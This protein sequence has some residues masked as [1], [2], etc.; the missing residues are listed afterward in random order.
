MYNKLFTKILDSSIW[1]APDPHRL[2][3][4]TLIA[5]MDEDGNAMFACADNL[6]A[7][8]RVSVKQAEAAIKSFQEPDPKSGDPDNEGMRIER[9]PG[10]WHVLNAHKYRS[11]VTKTISREQTRLRTAA[12]RERKRDASVTKCDEKVTPSEAVSVSVS[13]SEAKNKDMSAM[14]TVVDVFEHWKLTHNHPRSVLDVKRKKLIKSALNNYSVA[15]LCQ[16]ITGYLKSPHHMGMNEANTIYDDIELMLRDAKHIDAG[17][18]F[19]SNSPRTDLSSLT[20]K[21]VMATQDWQPPEMRN[22]TK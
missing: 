9:I 2:V 8:A 3:W 14:P 12:W 4:I 22:E 20:R 18:R 15:D 13:V 11:I 7:R 17:I 10:G 16:S 19:D 5:A 21:N 6:A 1:L